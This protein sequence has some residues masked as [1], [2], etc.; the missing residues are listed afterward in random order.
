MPK[1]PPLLCPEWQQEQRKR[2]GEVQQQ[3]QQ[4]TSVSQL[5]LV[6]EKETIVSTTYLLSLAN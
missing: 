1:A 4:L 5:E 2:G 6:L 3:Q